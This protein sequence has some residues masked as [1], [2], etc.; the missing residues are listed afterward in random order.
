M[1]SKWGASVVYTVQ[2]Y[3]QKASKKQVRRVDHSTRSWTH[4]QHI[5]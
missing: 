2:N 5:H 1:R 4:F 3:K